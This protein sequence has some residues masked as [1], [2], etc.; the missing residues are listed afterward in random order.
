MDFIVKKIMSNDI[1]AELEAIGF[2]EHYLNMGVK[3]HEFLNLKIFNVSPIQATIIKQTALS[4]GCDCAVNRDVLGHLI[5]NSNCI[6]SGSITQIENVIKKLLS[7]QFSLPVLSKLIENQI[8][9]D[10]NKNETSKI[11]GILNLSK[12]SFSKDL[13]GEDFSKSAIEKAE[14]LIEEGADIIDIGAESTKPN[15]IEVSSRE[16][17]EKIAPVIEFLKNQKCIISVDTRSAEVADF[18]L[19]KG[20]D[21]INDVS[22]LYDKSMANIIKKYQKPYI[23]TH[24]RG[25]PSNMDNFCNYENVVETVYIELKEKAENLIKN[26]ILKENIILDVGFGF[27]KNVEQNLKLVKHIE[28]FKSLGFK[29]LAGI[30]RKRVIQSFSN[31]KDVKELDFLTSLATF[32]FAQKN[33]DIIRVH[34]VK[35]AKQ[36]IEFANALI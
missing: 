3:K 19:S 33:V 13:V 21:I 27:A 18:A 35:E 15:A 24:S 4:A 11:M 1:K 16:Q 22:F 32:Y 20:A 36:T 14:I 2:D 6:L 17:I 29:I 34:N 25:I 9:I 28:E 12:N 31:S 7:Q 8:E 23:L 10:K 26:G 5:E 30:S